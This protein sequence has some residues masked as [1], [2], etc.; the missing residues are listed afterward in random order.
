MP[1]SLLPFILLIIP[2]AEIGM[3]IVVGSR[4]GVGWTLA[5]VVLTAVIGSVLLR[6]QG[7]GLLSKIQAETAAG[8]V[9]GRELV[10]GVMI[11]AA[12]ILLLTPGFITDA[13]GFLLF[14]PPVR[15]AV[16]A[17]LRKRMRFETVMTRGTTRS[18]PAED[19][20]VVDLD[21][22]EYRREPDRK[23]PWRRPRPRE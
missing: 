2:L 21:D 15:D 5:L 4:I 23:S 6:L 20:N 11:L 10:H 12:G 8:R 3:F 18:G 9:P 22:S 13:M 17:F 14:I 16:W 1:L 19:A 7:F